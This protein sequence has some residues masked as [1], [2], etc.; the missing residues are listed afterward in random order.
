LKQILDTKENRKSY[1]R[2]LYISAGITGGLCLIFALLGSGLMSFTGA[3]DRQ[4]EPEVLS[5]IILDRKAMLSGDEWRSLVFILLAAGALWY[6]ITKKFKTV[7]L[8]SILGVLIL[9]DLWG[10]D[11]RFLGEDDF[12]PKKRN[13]KIVATNA[14]KLILQDKDPDYRVLN[15]SPNMFNESQ[16]AYFHKSIGGYSPAKL[17]R[18]QDIIDYYLSGNLNRNVIDM[19]NTRYIIVQGEQGQQQVQQNL[20]AL[21]NVWFVNEVKWV[22]TPNQ[23]IE[24]LNDFNPVQTAII[25]KQWQDKLTGWEALQH[26]TDSSAVIRLS[27]YANPGYLIYESSSSKPSLAVFSEVFYKTWK[28]YI[29]GQE[30]PVIRVNYILRG[31]EI[32]AGAHKIEFKCVDEIFQKGEKISVASSWLT[33]ILIIGLSGLLIWRERKRVLKK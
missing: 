32:P 30:V 6:Y 10:V 26:E 2:P 9:V 20:G 18:Y 7:Y 3:A 5:A 13:S 16:T 25:D 22:D 8:V 27:D 28:A 23:E 31:L 15:H 4:H 1:L 12:I 14:D 24:A 21:G 19:L 17:Q 11:K 29:D 33:G